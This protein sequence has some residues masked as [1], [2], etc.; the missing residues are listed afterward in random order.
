MFIYTRNFVMIHQI[1]PLSAIILI[2]ILIYIFT[3]PFP[4]VSIILVKGPVE[5]SCNCSVNNTAGSGSNVT[6]LIGKLL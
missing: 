1:V 2:Y 5:S 4:T 6:T 3:E